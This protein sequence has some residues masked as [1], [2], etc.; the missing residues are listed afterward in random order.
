MLQPVLGNSYWYFISNLPKLRASLRNPAASKIC[1]LPICDC[2]LVFRL[3]RVSR[4]LRVQFLIRK[5]SYDSLV[6]DLPVTGSERVRL[7]GKW[8]KDEIDDKEAW[9][10][11]V[12]VEINTENVAPS[13][14]RTKSKKQDI[15]GA[16]V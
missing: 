15:Y 9:L 6:N 4:Q 11:I 2:N 5:G 13:K 8:I 10:L 7:L 12:A 3:D 14:K 16:K 1:A